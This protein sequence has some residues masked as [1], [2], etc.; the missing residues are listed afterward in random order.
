MKLLKNVKSVGENT[1]T[2]ALTTTSVDSKDANN[3]RI[4]NF[5]GLPVTAPLV[6]Y[7]GSDIA[8]LYLLKV[9]AIRF[10]LKLNFAY[11]GTHYHLDICDLSNVML[12]VVGTSSMSCAWA[13]TNSILRYIEKRNRYVTH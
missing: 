9:L 8:A 11:N 13:I 6:D 7:T 10:K 4:Q 1:M 5:L 12:D 2:N 3:I